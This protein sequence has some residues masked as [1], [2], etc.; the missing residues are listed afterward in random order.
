MSFQI[1][2]KEHEVVLALEG[3]VR[4]SSVIEFKEILINLLNNNS[5]ITINISSIKAIDSAVIQLLY[6]LFKTAAQKNI[7]MELQGVSDIFT[8][9]LKAA[10]LNKINN[11]E[12]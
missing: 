2:K 12:D 6:S 9:A 1:E 10:G 8:R 4:I 5:P 3:E 11:P 7:H